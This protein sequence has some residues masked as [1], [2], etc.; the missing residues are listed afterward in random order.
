MS[1]DY[2]VPTDPEERAIEIALDPWVGYARTTL[3]FC[4]LVYLALGVALGPLM[5][6]PFLSDPEQRTLGIVMTI[7]YTAVSLVLGVGMGVLN[8]AAASGLGRGKKWA[9]F[10]SVGL[11]AL[12]LPTGC[13]LFGLVLMFAMLKDKT[14]KLF[15]SP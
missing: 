14:R 8:L 7:V 2:L 9:W 11:G 4:G 3:W 6:L 5:G 10:V 13:C 1:D 12:Y 15:L